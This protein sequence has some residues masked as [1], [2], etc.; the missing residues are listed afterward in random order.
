MQIIS[1]HQPAIAHTSRHQ[2]IC[3]RTFTINIYAGFGSLFFLPSGTSKHSRIDIS[4]IF[5]IACQPVVLHDSPGFKTRNAP[6]VMRPA[7]GINP[8]PVLA[9]L[10]QTHLQTHRC[11][12][13]QSHLIQQ[14][15][16]NRW[17]PRT[18]RA[19]LFCSRCAGNKLICHRFAHNK[20][21][22]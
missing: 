9:L 10:L 8:V 14:Y 18:R 13:M 21:I 22:S 20:T 7:F 15:R 2:A 1:I 19:I 6:H 12:R 3:K 16:H 4:Q 11:L 17:F 5:L